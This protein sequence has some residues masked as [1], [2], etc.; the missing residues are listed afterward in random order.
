M[1]THIVMWKLT[2]REALATNSALIKEKLE[3]LVGVV[4]G[5]VNAEV[6]IGFDGFDLALSCTLESREALAVY[7]DHPEHV[8]VKELIGSIACERAFCDY[9][10]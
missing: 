2:D 6:G 4:P 1:V 10:G 8:K 5:L 9:E 7:Q 3:A